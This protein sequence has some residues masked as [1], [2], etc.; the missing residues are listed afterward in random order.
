MRRCV[1]IFI[2]AVLGMGMLISSSGCGVMVPPIPQSVSETEDVSSREESVSQDGE[3]SS[4]PEKEE[5]ES[6]A[7]SKVVSRQEIEDTFDYGSYKGE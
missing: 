6:S 1:S 5:S 2:C 7:E 3:N 4:I